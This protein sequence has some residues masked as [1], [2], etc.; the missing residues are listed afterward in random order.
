LKAADT[1]WGCASAN[2]FPLPGAI[3]VVCDEFAT[4]ISAYHG[5]DPLQRSSDPMVQR[6]RARLAEHLPGLESEL[7]ELFGDVDDGATAVVC[8]DSDGIVLFLRVGQDVVDD[9]FGLGL[10]VGMNW[11]KQLAALPRETVCHAAPVLAGDRSHAAT[12]AILSRSPSA[13]AYTR[14]LTHCLARAV[15]YRAAAETTHRPLT[16]IVPDGPE[17]A[18]HRERL[19]VASRVAC[20]DPGVSRSLELA[21]RLAG[22]N[23][24]ILL[25]GETGT[26]KEVFARAVHIL[27]H[28]YV[29]PFVAVNCASVPESLIES[30]LFGYRPG[31]FSGASRDGYRGRIVQADG[32]VL[33]LDEIGDMPT[34]LQARLLRVLETMEVT[35]LGSDDAVRV[36][37]QIIS[38]THQDLEQNVRDGLFR[39]DLYY[40]LCGMRINLPSLRERDGRRTLLIAVLDEESH[41]AAVFERSALDALDAYSW[42]GNVRELRNTVRVAL[43]LA[44]DGVVRVQHLPPQI[45]GRLP[46]KASGGDERSRLLWE[47][48]QHRWNIS[49]VAR[50]LGVSRNTLYRRMRRLSIAIPGQVVEADQAARRPDQDHGES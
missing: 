3:P 17:L 24:P 8:A 50:V 42:P 15:S 39:G 31:A 33:F 20:G 43:A 25:I 46:G 41:G 6:R 30:E 29:G 48:E 23:I 4:M 22:R 12:V 35:P 40:R 11:H 38:A 44:E 21:Q 45:T 49:A 28:R 13:S 5:P 36:N 10:W 34:A 7:D 19:A 27:S 1:L 32:G 26:G 16:P 2:G 37:I 9:I 47:I 18:A 14:A